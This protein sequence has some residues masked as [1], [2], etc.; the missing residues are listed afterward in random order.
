MSGAAPPRP[1]RRGTD[2]PRLAMRR[3]ARRAA[4]TVH[5]WSGG[6]WIGMDLVLAILVATALRTD[7]LSLRAACFQ[8]FELFAV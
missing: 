3:P 2:P 6:A 7:D 1:V 5:L 8:A 4:L